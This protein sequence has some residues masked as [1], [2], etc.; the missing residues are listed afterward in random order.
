MTIR[1]SGG[2]KLFVGREDVTVIHKRGVKS[3]KTKQKYPEKKR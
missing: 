1:N 3:E 2:R